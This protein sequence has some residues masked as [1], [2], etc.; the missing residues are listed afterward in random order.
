MEDGWYI[1]RAT[2]EILVN[3][4]TVVGPTRIRSG[5]VVR[6]SESGPD[7]SFSIVSGAALQSTKQPGRAAGPPAAAPVPPIVPSQKAPIYAPVELPEP[8]PFSAAA[9]SRPSVIMT[10]TGPN[11]SKAGLKDY[12][13]FWGAGGLAICVIFALL[14]RG[15]AP[16]TVEVKLI[17]PSANEKENATA[18]QAQPGQ[19]AQAS[20]P[21]AA[22]SQS[23]QQT[24]TVPSSASPTTEQRIAAQMKD[25]VFLIQVEKSGSFWP[26]AS[27]CAIGKHSLLT[28]AR[29]ASSLYRWRM[30]PGKEFKIWITNP[31]TGFKTGVED[32]YVNAMYATLENKPT[33]W[34]YCDYALLTVAADLP[35]V[36][37][38]AS[39]EEIAKLK[40]GLPVYCSGFTHEGEKVSEFS[41][42]QPQL[43]GGKIFIITAQPNLPSRPRLL[44]MKGKFFKNALGAPIVNDQGKVVAVYGE[45]IQPE[46]DAAAQ[47]GRNKMEIHLAPVL[48]AEFM[49]LGLMQKYENV[50]IHPD[51]SGTNTK[52][53]DAK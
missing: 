28:S 44:N 17:T 13:I 40:D 38:L 11:Q 42:F 48:N 49:K 10:S 7:F 24:S 9:P 39:P 14:M 19:S 53:K 50:W 20:T 45:A 18:G 23:P 27:C 37:P 6:M 21:A 36:L 34:I 41:D 8:E 1:A 32:I 47:A 2:G 31:A 5:D 30:D 43:A 51:V 4:Q 52:S 12:W 16:T 25:A 46:Q 35:K 22:D 33:D 29:E 3:Q 26:F 15:T